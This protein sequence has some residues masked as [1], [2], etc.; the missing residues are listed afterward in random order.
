MIMS[1][2]GYTQTLEHR[3]KISE[4]HKS[5]GDKHWSKRPEVIE[6]RRKSITGEKNHNFGK[7]MSD[8]QKKKISL[9][10]IG[11]KP[12]EISKEKNRIAHIGLNMGTDH[13]L[14]KRYGRG[15]PS[16]KKEVKI[17]DNYTCQVCGLYDKEI[18]EI[19]HIQPASIFPDMEKKIDNLVCLCPNC[20]RRKTKRDRKAIREYKRNAHNLTTT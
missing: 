19:D 18:I 12:T 16:L 13:W 8:E 5:F 17:R 10:H 9:S 6:K 20:H 1:L 4:T 15:L 7:A 3:R 14:V 11:I 2:K